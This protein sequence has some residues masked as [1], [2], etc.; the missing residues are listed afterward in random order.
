MPPKTN[1]RKPV[2]GDHKL[3]NKSERQNNKTFKPLNEAVDSG[4]AMGT[5]A[6]RSSP[7][8]KM[9]SGSPRNSPRTSPA[10][11]NP[12]PGGRQ[13]TPSPGARPKQLPGRKNSSS[14]PKSAGV[15]GA[16]GGSAFTINHKHGRAPGRAVRSPENAR[17]HKGRS[18]VQGKSST[19]SS[20][21]SSSSSGRNRG[22]SGSASSSSA[23]P[24]VVF[25][26][27]EAMGGGGSATCCCVSI[28][29]QGGT[30]LAYA[31]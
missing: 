13:N 24:Y 20:S 14:R 26:G 29:Q 22:G 5:E 8:G 30:Q 1:A 2:K 15:L 12:S 17:S 21:S 18:P 10:R 4:A 9:K 25:R 27:G 28:G 7:S 16:Y 6:K 19:S 23:T 11:Q 31:E 3:I